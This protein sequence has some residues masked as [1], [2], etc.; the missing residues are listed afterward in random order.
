RG[1]IPPVSGEPAR[2]RRSPTC[3]RSSRRAGRSV[4][5]ARARRP[6]CG[7]PPRRSWRWPARRSRLRRSARRAPPSRP[8]DEQRAPLQRRIASAPVQIGVPKE[9][10][11][12]ERRVALVPDIVRKLAAQGH[13]VVVELA[14]GAAAGIPDELFEAAGASFGAPWRADVV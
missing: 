7:S 9:V 12:G 14:A 2:G 13:D 8:R 4:T 10:V 5:P 6:P 1:A 11:S 3:A